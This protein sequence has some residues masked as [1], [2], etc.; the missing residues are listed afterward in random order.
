MPLLKNCSS[1]LKEAGELDF[2]QII[3]LPEGS[4]KEF[5][6]YSLK[7]K[8]F[9]GEGKCKLEING[10]VKILKYGDI[11]DINSDKNNPAFLTSLEPSIIIWIGGTW[12]EETGSFGVFTINNSPNPKNIGD[13][14]SYSRKTEFDNHYHDCDEY[15]IIFRGSA[16][17]VSENKFYKIN[18]GEALFTKAGDHHDL[19]EVYQTLKGV[20]FETSLK[21]LKRKGHL[22]VH[23]H[24]H[25][26][27]DEELTK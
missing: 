4:V 13:P 7:E 1:I 21:G 9:I 3:K 17:V 14:V 15:W 19:P 12:S 8:L 2:Y 11:F 25:P 22:W 6:R 16:L 18:E 26:K 27:N 20:Y 5:P 24:G 10:E 23:T